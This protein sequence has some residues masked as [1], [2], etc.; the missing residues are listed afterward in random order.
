MEN[1][2]DELT[3]MAS[4]SALSGG[5]T[6]QQS[7]I[8]MPTIPIFHLQQS[9][10]ETISL[11]A[12]GTQ[13]TSVMCTGNDLVDRSAINTSSFLNIDVSSDAGC[14]T[15]AKGSFNC[16][17]NAADLSIDWSNSL[18]RP[19]SRFSISNRRECKVKSIFYSLIY[20]SRF[21]FFSKDLPQS[22][23]YLFQKFFIW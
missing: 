4:S 11:I 12:G 15:G 23:Y 13:T 21:Y 16:A 5:V 10:S 1:N 6:N 9:A 14:N 18:F 7:S 2:F 22:H 20:L 8:L 3:P 17:G 19:A